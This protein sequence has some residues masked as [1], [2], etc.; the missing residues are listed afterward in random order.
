MDA[1][2]SR[3]FNDNTSSSD[4][5]IFAS[6][7]PSTDPT[8]HPAPFSSVPLSNLPPTA[9]HAPT[10]FLSS[11]S[12]DDDDDNEL[13]GLSTNS[14]SF[15]REAV[16]KP[17]SITG[18]KSSF[19]IGHKLGEGAYATVKEGIDERS[20]RI[21]A[22]KVL[23][24]RRLRK[25]RGGIEAIEREVAVMKRLKRHPNL[26]ELI[27]VVR[28][29]AKSKM[30]IILEMANGCTVQELAESVSGKRVPESQVAHFVY[31]TLKGLQYM[32]GKGVVHRDIKPSNM[33]L[34]SA[35]ELKITDF[36][37]AEF[38]D[39]YNSEDNVS[40]TSGSPAFQAPEIAKGDEDYSG[41]KVDVWALGVTMYLLLSG[42]IPF[43]AENL[44]SLFELI[45][46]GRY[47]EPEDMNLVCRD[48]ISRMLRVNWKERE[49]VDDLL[50]HPWV[51]RGG[52][53]L[54]EQQR[55]EKGWISV[56]RREFGILD[57]VKRMYEMDIEQTDSSSGVPASS[58]TAISANPQPIPIPHMGKTRSEEV[59]CSVQ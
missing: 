29:P 19:I 7:V 21:V 47:E 45:G 30:Y 16:P 46:E 39:N 6:A 59:A 36:G 23:D 48:V 11:S 32:H 15:V 28:A 25:V 54:S 12:D 43:E 26:I 5:S 3:S 13:F 4:D 22:V 8:I 55:Q 57:I 1:T 14:V 10:S 33:M 51:V 24:L 58:M 52:Q 35:G 40:R 38:L 34:T 27:D 18:T 9:F 2:W 31:Q 56:T 41:M 49:S 42:K 37:V 44:L 20:L 50:K 17:K 53:Q